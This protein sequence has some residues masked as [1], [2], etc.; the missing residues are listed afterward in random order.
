MLNLIAFLGPSGVGKS[1][2]QG[3]LGYN[4]IVTWTSRQPRAGEVDGVH[5]HFADND[6]ILSM[7]HQGLLLEYTQYNGNLY[8]IALSSLKEIIDNNKKAAVAV[9]ANGAR[10]LKYRFGDAVLVI[11]VIAPYEECKERLLKRDDKNIDIRL[12]TYSQEVNTMLELSDVII[13]N[14]KANYQKAANLVTMIELNR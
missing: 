3:L 7:Y 4:K 6:K 8:G 1:T 5:Y 9:D 2:L 13:N 14:S 10:E 11:G 12:A